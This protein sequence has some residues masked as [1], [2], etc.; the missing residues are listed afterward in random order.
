M[1]DG[2]VAFE[3]RYEQR[4]KESAGGVFQ[5]CITLGSSRPRCSFVRVVPAP[6]SELKGVQ[7]KLTTLGY[8]DAQDSGVLDVST[9]NALRAFQKEHSPCMNG[10]ASDGSTFGCRIIICEVGG[11]N[12]YP[13]TEDGIPGPIT[14]AVMACGW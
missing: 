1:L 7:Q 9:R 11:M 14:R 8:L 13:P 3:W 2:W 5:G 6:L 12:A 4:V 10:I